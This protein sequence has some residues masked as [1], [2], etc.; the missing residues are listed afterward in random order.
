[1]YKHGKGFDPDVIRH[2][3]IE[4]I[5]LTVESELS[6]CL[7]GQTQNANESLDALIWERAPK[8]RY[9]GLAKLK[10][11]VYDAVS[12]FNYGALSIID[13]LKLL[14]ID[15][16]RYTLKSAVDANIQRRYNAGY[17]A[18]TTSMKRRKVIR[19]LKKKKGDNI[20]KKEGIM[21]EAGGF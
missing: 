4:Y 12:Y 19:G 16:G 15:A 13:T 11:C 9:C 2:V 8:T 20:K 10:L 5:K 14:G 17:K 18:K 7:H 1:M 6:K 3:K 21:Y